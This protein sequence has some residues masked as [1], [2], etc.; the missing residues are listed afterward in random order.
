MRVKQ[1]DTDAVRVLAHPLRVRIVGTL[2]REGPATATLL[3]SR[4]GASSGLTSYHVAE[5]NQSGMM[6][7]VRVNEA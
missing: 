3:A 1:L 4:L 6:L 7:S 2:R 5:H